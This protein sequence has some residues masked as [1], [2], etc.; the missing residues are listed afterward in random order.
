MDLG[1]MKKGRNRKGKHLFVFSPRKYLW[2][3]R[4]LFQSNLTDTITASILS[5]F[6][7]SILNVTDF[8]QT[9]CSN[10]KSLPFTIHLLHI[11]IYDMTISFTFFND[12][13]F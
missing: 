13:V 2:R 5:H 8:K 1:V 10:N 11:F 7:V 9:P 4:A 6:F 12:L 3:R